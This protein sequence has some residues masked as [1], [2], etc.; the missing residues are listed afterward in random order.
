MKPILCATA[1]LALAACSPEPADPS[2]NAQTLPA[3]AN[4]PTPSI[5]P[6]MPRPRPSPGAVAANVLTLDGLGPLRIG[7]PVPANSSWA[8]RGA[9]ISDAC[10]TVSSPD[11]PGTYAIVE[12]GKVR[13]VTVGERSD[14]KLVEGIG[15]GATEAEVRAAFAG[16][17]AEPHAYSESPAKYLTAPNAPSGDPALRFEIGQDGK[18][19]L[20][21][22]GTMPVLGYVEGCA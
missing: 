5:P 20:I 13:R 3:E 1:L 7:E 8:E 18:V 22:V 9:Q 4:A 14:V 6:P 11:F 15:V 21:H 17:R 2:G 12:G 10:R 16:F 19:A